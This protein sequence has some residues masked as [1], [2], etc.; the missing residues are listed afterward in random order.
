[1]KTIKHQQLTFKEQRV[2]RELRGL[3]LIHTQSG[4]FL[5]NLRHRIHLIRKPLPLLCDSKGIAVAWSVARVQV[6][7]VGA[8]AKEVRVILPDLVITS[9]NRKSNLYLSFLILTHT[10]PHSR[11]TYL[12]IV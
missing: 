5:H 8:L 10:L 7:P 1:M 6:E 2:K 9:V 3:F 12:K 4:M 11:K